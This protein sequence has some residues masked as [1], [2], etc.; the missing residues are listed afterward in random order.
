MLWALTQRRLLMLPVDR[1]GEV[2][3]VV[4]ALSLAEQVQELVV[5]R[6]GSRDVRVRVR[7]DGD[8]IDL[9]LHPRAD[10]VHLVELL[11]AAG[12]GALGDP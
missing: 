7:L 6:V 12:C 10:A 9:R 4:T 1:S 5:R 11:R 2:G 8:R 3:P